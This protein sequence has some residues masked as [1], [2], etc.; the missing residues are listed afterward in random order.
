MIRTLPELGEVDSR[1]VCTAVLEDGDVRITLL[2]LGCITADW[3]VGGRPVVLGYADPARYL[4]DGNSFGIIAGRVAN[5]IAYGRFQLNDRTIQ[6]DCNQPPHHLHG[7][8]RGLGKRNWSMEVAGDRAVRFTYT[9][10]DG[11]EGYPGAVDF[12]VTVTLD[13]H[14]LTYTMEAKPDRE[15]PVNLAQHSYYNLAGGP[16]WEHELQL[17]APAHTPT[18][19][20]LIPTGEIVPVAGTRYDFTLSRPLGT[21]DTG[22]LGT[23]MNVVLDLARNPKIPAAILRAGG[24]QLRLWTGQPGLQLYNAMH[25][26]PTPCGHDGQTYDR[27]HGLCLEAQHF[28][29]SPNRPEFPSILCSPDAPYR[30]TLMVEIAPEAAL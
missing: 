13:R 6:L 22:H 2:S 7:G 19:D 14:R 20:T 18:D 29:D 15:T 1:P 30:Q 4:T 10:P 17:A 28:P 26:G 3:R 25:L 12:A 11:E 27:F 9:S 8:V 23:D 5:R 24:L 21:A 16:V